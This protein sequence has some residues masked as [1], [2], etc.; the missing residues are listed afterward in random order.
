MNPLTA[1]NETPTR[2][3][4]RW[5]ID[6]IAI[7]LTSFAIPQS[8]LAVDPPPDGGYPN[9]NTAEGT[10]A[11]LNLTTGVN[12]TAIG[13]GALFSNT[14]AGANTAVGF[15]AL[16]T[17]SGD[18][19]S[20]NTAIGYRALL[21]NRSGD[22]NTAVGLEAVRTNTVGFRNTAIGEWALLSNTGG[23]NNTATGNDALLNNRNGRDNTATGVS[24]LTQNSSGSFNTAAG[25]GA[26]DSNWTGNNNTALGSEALLFNF[27]DNKNTA[28]GNDA[29]VNIGLV[30]G[31]G[32]KNIALG[33]R[34]GANLSTGSN[35]IHIGAEGL[36]GD[37]ET[38]RIGTVGVQT[39]AYIQGISRA[40]VASGVTVIVGTQGHL[41]TIQSS[42]QF[43]DEIHP[44]DK[45]SE[46][47][48]AL[49]PVTFRYKHEL[50]PDGRP[51]FGLIAEQVEKVNPDLVVRDQDGKVSTVRYDAVNAML[52]NEFLKEHSKVE[53]QEARLS[54]QETTIAQQQK[55]IE[56]L[57]A[58]VQKVNQQI[59]ANRPVPQLVA[60]GQ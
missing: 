39:S 5:A 22:G 14:T 55:Q 19:A 52:L 46:A 24:A 2:L 40:T 20:G 1:Q 57:T 23:F 11:L 47:I 17:N 18:F 45:A 54:K 28:I 42:A 30:V 13:E 41:G 49:K 27:S 36:A 7:V 12:N 48:L 10:N 8:V 15:K 34:A 50:D 51:Q 9:G 21:S 29:L 25:S 58:T 16:F 3:W 31:G 6:I 33:Y 26:L 56:T 37:S 43:K 53:Q 32:S 4:L 60:Y 59:E 35:N 38:I 44:M